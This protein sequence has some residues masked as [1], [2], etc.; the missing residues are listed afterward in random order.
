MS[1]ATVWV[2]IIQFTQGSNKQKGRERANLLPL[3]ELRHL[4]SGLGHG[5]PSLRLLV[6]DEDLYHWSPNS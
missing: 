4:S 3:L 6:S 2:G 1:P 5:C